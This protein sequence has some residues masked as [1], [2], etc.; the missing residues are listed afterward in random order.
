MVNSL[1]IMTANSLNVQTDLKGLQ[2]EIQVQE[3]IHCYNN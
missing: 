3:I 1:I 2:Q